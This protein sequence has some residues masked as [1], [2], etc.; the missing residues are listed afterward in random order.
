MFKTK[1]NKKTLLSYLKKSTTKDVTE[2][3]KKYMPCP[4]DDTPRITVTELTAAGKVTKREVSAVGVM[5]F[6]LS[7]RDLSGWV[8]DFLD[9]RKYTLTRGGKSNSSNSNS[10][11]STGDG[12]SERKVNF[13]RAGLE[14]TSFMGSV[15]TRAPFAEAKGELAVFD[16]AQLQGCSFRQAVLARSSF[17]AANLAQAGLE[18]VEA[19][20]ANFSHA[21]LEG[22][23][24]EGAWFC[25]GDVHARMK[26][27]EY[28]QDYNLG[29]W[30]GASF[31]AASLRRAD[32]RGAKLCGVDFS[33]ADLTG[34]YLQNAD[35]R[36]A[37]L[38]GAKLCGANLS[39]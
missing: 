37:N 2:W 27:A 15:C 33:G 16:S 32:L 5:P 35:L 10:S 17:I 13:T 3:C 19:P 8:M 30:E 7:E 38:T 12:L 28:M 1:P 20:R 18:A 26:D 36:F 31:A 21:N 4:E 34:A 25:S 14:R 6:N 9:M 23:V 29:M 22:A 11:S 39:K 24:L